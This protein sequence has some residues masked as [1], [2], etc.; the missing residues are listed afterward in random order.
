MSKNKLPRNVVVISDT[1]VGGRTAICPDIVHLDDGGIYTPSKQQRVLKG[2]WDEFWGEFVPRVTKGEPYTVVHNG[3]CVDGAPHGSVAQISHLMDDQVT[4]AVDLLKPVLDGPKV[5]AY[6]HIRGTEAHVG[7]SG[8]LEDRTAC[9]LG[10][11]RDK[12]GRFARWDLWLRMGD[13]GSE[14]IIHFLHHIGSTG[15]THYESSA[16]MA[17]L[18]AELTEAA[19]WGEKPASAIVRSH[20]HRAIEVR[21]PSGRGWRF[22]VV[23]PAWQMRTPFSWKI[24]GARVSPP[25]I[26][27]I[28]LRVVDGYLFTVPFVKH[29]KREDHE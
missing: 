8:E 14:H 22:A 3:D 2:W 4:A 9:A 13:L 28:V 24:P 26:G 5:R 12:D 21:I 7:K 6:Y 17:E 16:V 25:Q 29:I 11:V 27:G 18:A 23:T 1:H 10:A 19:R 20:R 15:S